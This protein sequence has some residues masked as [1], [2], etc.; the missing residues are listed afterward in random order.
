M[1]K[2]TAIITSAWTDSC[3]ICVVVT[4]ANFSNVCPTI[5]EDPKLETWLTMLGNQEIFKDMDEAYCWFQDNGIT[6]VYQQFG[7][8]W[9]HRVL[10]F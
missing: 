3:G 8:I 5:L 10:E 9:D 4:P 1:M 7:G 2:K 6:E